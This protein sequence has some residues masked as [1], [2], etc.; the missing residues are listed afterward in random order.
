MAEEGYQ[1]DIRPAL[2]RTSLAFINRILAAITCRSASV[3]Y[4][5]CPAAAGQLSGGHQLTE[6]KPVYTG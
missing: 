2:A 5:T 1:P 3:F 4:G 6:F